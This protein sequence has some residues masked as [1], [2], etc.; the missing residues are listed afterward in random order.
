[1]AAL[2]ASVPL[3]TLLG[4]ADPTR[5]E[6]SRVVNIPASQLPKVLVYLRGG[7]SKEL[8]DQSPRRYEVESELVVEFTHSHGLGQVLE[9]EADAAGDV[10]ET[11][12]GN[13]EA[14]FF[15]GLVR[16]SRWI[17]TDVV[18]SSPPSGELVYATQLRQL[19]I[20]DRFVGV[21]SVDDFNTNEVETSIGGA[22][23]VNPTDSI[24]LP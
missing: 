23:D 2:R 10:L 4:D 16:D 14:T 3:Q 6:A 7:T 22:D 12:V 19:L 15:G 11:I 9:D 1:M 5:V 18:A 13:L 21:D 8:K 24:T 20:Y 17:G